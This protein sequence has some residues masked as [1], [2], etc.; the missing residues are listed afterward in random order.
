MSGYLEMA[1][2]AARAAGAI[3]REGWRKAVTVREMSRHDIKLQTDVDCETVI[4]RMLGDAFPE[5]AVLGEEG[6]GMI[7]EAQPTWIVD[8]LDGTVNFSRQIPHFCTSIALQVA[9]RAVVGV[10]YDPLLD[11]CFTAEA[12]QG[13][14]LNGEP[15][16]VSTAQGLEEAHIA[17][18]FSK[19]VENIQ[20]AVG[21]ITQLASAVRKV[22]MLGAAALDLAYV[23]AGRLDG[24]LEYGL[25]PWDIAAGTLLVREAG[26]RVHVAAAPLDTWDVRADNGR[27]W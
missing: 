13:A 14:F 17:I 4:R 21:E 5:H 26:G 6:G 16:H 8:P 23:A 19:Y 22:R 2:A 9:G 7:A 1:V 12:E 15:I 25:H 20:R 24:F 10:I 27:V 3:Q 18:G 11:E